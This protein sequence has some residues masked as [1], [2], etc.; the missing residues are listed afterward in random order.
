MYKKEIKHVTKLE[1]KD[2]SSLYLVTFKHSIEYEGQKVTKIQFWLPNNYFF[3]KI[4]DITLK[5]VI[6]GRLCWDFVHNEYLI[7]SNF[8]NRFLDKFSTKKVKITVEET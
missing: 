3:E 8:L 5:T 4:E 7:D 6:E 1:T 2:A